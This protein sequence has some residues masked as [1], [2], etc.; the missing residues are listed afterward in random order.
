MGQAHKKKSTRKEGKIRAH[1]GQAH[2]GPA[3]KMKAQEKKAS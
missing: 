2:I 3:D 1:M